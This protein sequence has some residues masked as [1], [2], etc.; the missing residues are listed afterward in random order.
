VE[1]DGAGEHELSV[2]E[3]R[4]RSDVPILVDFL[5]LFTHKKGTMDVKWRQ[6]PNCACYPL[7]PSVC[8][9]DPKLDSFALFSFP[10]ST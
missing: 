7:H 8:R 4:G 6:P 10:L 9:S 3:Q 1:A 2:Q 5:R